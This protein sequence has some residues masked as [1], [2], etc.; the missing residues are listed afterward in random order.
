MELEFKR[1]FEEALGKVDCLITPV[2][3]TTAF[4][5][6]EKIGDP[7]TMYLSDIYTIS[8]NLAGLPGISIPCGFDSKRMPVSFQL[9][10]QLFGEETILRVGHAYQQVTDFH[11]KMPPTSDWT[12]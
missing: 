8:T 4:K 5:I 2:S 11:K 1:D 3:P 9:L 12:R 6:G 7:L 10:G